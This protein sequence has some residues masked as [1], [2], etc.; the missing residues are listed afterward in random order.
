MRTAVAIVVTSL[1]SCLSGCE[2]AAS[3]KSVV[4]GKWCSES[5]A[6][7]LALTFDND[8]F[9]IAT[10]AEGVVISGTY[11]LIENVIVAKEAEG[12]EFRWTYEKGDR[13]ITGSNSGNPIYIR[14]L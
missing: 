8:Q 4:D 11:A 1:L 7:K 6:D 14:C 5:G 3:E 9:K 10:E 12:G 2:E 13:I